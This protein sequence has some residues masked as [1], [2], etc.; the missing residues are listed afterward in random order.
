MVITLSVDAGN[1]MLTDL[2]GRINAGGAGG[3]KIYSGTKPATPDT[4]I[5]TQVLLAEL[6]CA[7][8]AGS[9]ADKTLT[10]G[11]ITQDSAANASGTATWARIFSG[12]GSAVV[13]VD[14]SSTGGTAFL[15]M[16]TTSI[17]AGGPVLINS[18]V[19]TI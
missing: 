18:M 6:T 13:D 3:V 7:V 12:A 10:F 5:T 2:L 17:V 15:K 16:S 19:I 1:G 4:A 8:N 9:V 14:V 11:T